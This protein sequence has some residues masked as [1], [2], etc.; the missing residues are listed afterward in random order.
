MLLAIAK[1]ILVGL[2]ILLGSALLAAFGILCFELGVASVG[3]FLS[4]VR[5][6]P[7]V[8]K[9][10]FALIFGPLTALWIVVCFGLALSSFIPLPA[11][12]FNWLAPSPW[13]TQVDSWLGGPGEQRLL[14]RLS[15]SGFAVLFSSFALGISLSCFFSIPEMVRKVHTLFDFIAVLFALAMG[16]VFLYLSIVFS[17]GVVTG[18]M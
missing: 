6:Q 18:S 12:L 10:T 15:M 9:L 2:A 1:T 7:G 5:E 11:L 3:S 14:T 16:I 4:R 17:V 13:V 8:R